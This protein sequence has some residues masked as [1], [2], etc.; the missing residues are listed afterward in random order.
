MKLRYVI[1][2]SVV[3]ALIAISCEADN[4]D[5]IPPQ[6]EQPDVPEQPEQPIEPEQPEEPDGVH[7]EARYSSGAYYGDEYSPGVDC[8]F[9]SLSDNGFDERG[10]VRPNSTYYRLDIYAPKY[11][12]EY[13]E[14][15]SLPVGEYRL[16]AED[17]YAEWT[18]SADGSEYVATGE[19][20]V[21]RQLKFEAGVLLVTAE[22]TTLTVVVEGETHVVT[23]A[24]E[25]LI[26]NM[27]PRPMESRE[28]S[29][30]HAYALYYGDKFN[31]GVADNFYLY[32]S[33]KGL[34]ELG[35]EIAEGTYYG[36]D[37]YIGMVDSTLPPQLP[38]GTYAWDDNDTLAAGT[39]SAYYTKYYVINSD[40]TGYADARYPDWASITVAE[41]GVSAEVRFG[42]AVHRIV[43]EGVV[44]VFDLSAEES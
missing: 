43:Y 9:I 22:S 26:A 10:Y 4:N 11:E 38:Y 13:C 42:E 32:L 30:E 27:L 41:E 16:D 44:E 24:G 14:Y 31:I 36:F 8:Y 35:F 12:G 20:E 15:M 21:V 3:F 34:D 28:W 40:A 33:N 7:F 25:H 6:Q 5:P 29:V 19:S 18:F 2:L 1:S 39:I 23:F 37:L 17:S